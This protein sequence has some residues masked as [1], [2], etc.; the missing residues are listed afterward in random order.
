[1]GDLSYF[2]RFVRVISNSHATK[3]FALSSSFRHP[4]WLGGKPLAGMAVQT[5]HVYRRHKARLESIEFAAVRQCRI[6]ADGKVP[7]LPAID[8][9][10]RGLICL[11][12]Y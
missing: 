5:Q 2:Y 10:K 7:A 1:M 9:G 8:G 3:N 12:H 6:P 11:L 4:S